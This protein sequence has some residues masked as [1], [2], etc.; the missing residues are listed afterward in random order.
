MI[1][2][3]K[4]KTHHKERRRSFRQIV[5]ECREECASR[6]EKRRVAV[7]RGL[8]LSRRMELVA[9]SRAQI[10]ALRDPEDVRAFRRAS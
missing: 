2:T 1:N 6:R 4:R 9:P 5:A 10:L 7:R 3:K 8:G